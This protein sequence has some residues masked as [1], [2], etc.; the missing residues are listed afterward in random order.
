MNQRRVSQSQGHSYANVTQNEEV[1]ASWGRG[2]REGRAVRSLIAQNSLKMEMHKF[3]I[4]P[5]KRWIFKIFEG[6]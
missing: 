1:C 2:G 6:P 3:S 4:H 5:S